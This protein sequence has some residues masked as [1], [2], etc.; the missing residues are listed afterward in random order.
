[1]GRGLGAPVRTVIVI[2]LTV[3][4]AGCFAAIKAGL[5]FAPPLLYAG[6]RAAIAGVALLLVAAALRSPLLPARRDW[7]GVIALG[8]SQTTLAFGGMF[9]SPGR[10][11]AGIASVLGNTQALV[12]LPLAALFLHE[13]MTRG[14]WIALALGLLG[15][16]LISSPAFVGQ[17][18]YGVSGL[19]WALAA[20]GGF[21]VGSVIV[22]RMQVTSD[23]LAV[24][25]WQLLLGS[26]PLFVGSMAFERGAALDWTP[27]FLGL[28]LFL[29]I[30]GTSLT[31]VVW[32]WLLRD[33]DL[34]RLTMFLFL[35]PAFG[36]GLA[37]WLFGETV[38]VLEVGGVAIIL[39]AIG[40]AT[41]ES[42]R[43]TAE[44]ERSASSAESVGGR[45]PVR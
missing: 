20:S 37:V 42:L 1:M 3:I 17:D 39:A 30:L 4:Y 7:L 13:T 41:R 27:R 10:T 16:S 35:V 25:A 32:Y 29:A 26:L 40:A 23:L 38:S 6:L 15:V 22:K 43:R 18:A 34:G 44:T 19:V 2:G 36:L 21:S 28:L 45:R 11:G 12:V 8:L 9:L 5:L 33:D 24:T 31:T 14:K